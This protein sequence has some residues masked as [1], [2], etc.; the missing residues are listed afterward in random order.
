MTPPIRALIVEDNPIVRSGLVTLLRAAGVEVAGEAVDGRHAIELAERLRPDIVLLDVRMP[1]LDGVAA[2]GPLSRIAKVLM[3]SY[4][5][6][7]EVIGEAIRNGASGYLVHGSFDMDELVTAIRDTVGER[8]SPLSPQASMAVVA[9]IRRTPP[10]GTPAPSRAEFGLTP[11][12]SAVMD[13]I[14]RGRTN[15]EIADDL[16]ISEFTVKNHV[17]R[18]FAKLG[19]GTRGAAIAR[20]LRTDEPTDP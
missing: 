14:A 19:V 20:W 3:L 15:A 2:A 16:V 9:A 18:I 4:D 17:N 10:A 8:D 11:R 5:T 12:E 13:L 1:I 7:A 6:D